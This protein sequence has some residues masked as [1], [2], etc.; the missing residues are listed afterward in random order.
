MYIQQVTLKN[1]R[2][3]ESL[4]INFKPPYAGWH[5]I[6]GDNA[7]GKST[8]LRSIA[9][10]F[11]STSL[12]AVKPY[13]RNFLRAGAKTG[14]IKITS[15]SNPQYDSWSKDGLREVLHHIEGKT[16][17][18]NDQKSYLQSFIKIKEHNLIEFTEPVEPY[19]SY[20]GFWFR[21]KGWFCASYGPFRRI[22]TRKATSVGD[23]W[24]ELYQDD[25]L[26][27]P[28]ISLFNPNI[29]FSFLI[30]WLRELRFKELEG[31]NSKTLSYLIKLIN[32]G[33]LLASGFKIVEVSSDGVLF[34]TPQGEIVPIIQLS[35]GYRSV[36]SITFDL[37]R[38]LI[39]RYGEDRVFEQI[40]KGNMLIDLP[41]VV[42]ID[43][44]DAHLHPSWQVRIGE[45]FTRFFPKMQFIVTTHS[46]LICQSADPGSIWR[47]ALPDSEIP[48]GEVTGSDYNRLVYGNVLDAYAT[49]LFGEN[50]ERSADATE[51]TDELAHLNLKALQGTLSTQEKQ[52]RRELQSL[53]PESASLIE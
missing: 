18:P 10:G 14:Q 7:T 50:V 3:F 22:D 40:A 28:H 41:G 32:E 45:W 1:I 33:G 42:M 38:H 46:P 21:D 34:E 31:K 37:L 2:A 27:A 51:M 13:I 29:L 6:I 48:S 17:P 49:D 12:E 24:D 35:D 52:R 39:L 20:P 36:L 53:L 9:L 25:P 47:L 44:V 16:L 30:V 11:L 5:V 8:L 4:E 19:Q 43:E 26:L 23:E 15:E